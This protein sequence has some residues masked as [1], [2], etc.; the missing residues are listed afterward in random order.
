MLIHV[1]LL[2]KEGNSKVIA[3]ATIP[4]S[5]THAAHEITFTTGEHFT[6]SMDSMQH[7]VGGVII[8]STTWT[9]D[10]G[11]TVEAI[12]RLFLN[13]DA[14]PLD[15]RNAPLVVALRRHYQLR[16][17]AASNALRSKPMISLLSQDEHEELGTKNV[18]AESLLEMGHPLIDRRLQLLH[19]RWR[20]L[21][22][23]LD[24]DEKVD[25]FERRMC[26][27]PIPS[28][29]ESTK[30][31]EKHLRNVAEIEDTEL[32]ETKNVIAAGGADPNDKGKAWLAKLRERKTQ[33]KPVIL[34]DAQK[35]AKI[36][37]V[38]TIPNPLFFIDKIKTWFVPQS[39]FNPKRELREEE[40]E[41]TDRTKIQEKWGA[42]TISCS[43][44]K[45][46]NLPIRDDGSPI[47]AFVELRFVDKAVCTHSMP[48]IAPSWFETLSVPFEPEDFADETLNFIDDDIVLSV[49][50]EVRVP[51][52]R[53][54]TS[55]A[56]SQV[57]HYRVERRFL[58]SVK[59]P[60]YTLYSSKKASIEASFRVFQP[61]VALGYVLSPFDMPTIDLFI[62]LNPPLRKN[63]IPDETD[64]QIRQ[65]LSESPAS[66][67]LKNLNMAALN[68]AV[69]AR[70]VVAQAT[71]F[72]GAAPSAR[73]V[74]PFANT[75]S[76]D[77]QLLCR[78]LRRDGI[79][80]P[81]GITSITEAIRFVSLFQFEVD[82]M[83]SAESDQWSTISE[84][85]N[86]GTGD[87]EEFAILL[88]LLI[89]RIEPG[90]PVYLV[91]GQGDVFP[92]AVYVLIFL[93]NVVD[94]SNP[95]NESSNTPWKLIDPRT[96]DVFD[97][98]S[99]SNRNITGLSDVSLVISHNQIWAN[100][101]PSGNP[102]RMQWNIDDS[103]YWLPMFQPS[104]IQFMQTIE[105][106]QPSDADIPWGLPA[107]K[108]D[109]CRDFEDIVRRQV[110]ETLRMLR[111][112]RNV[113]F[114]E[115]IAVHMR[116][117]LIFMEDERMISANVQHPVVLEAM[118]KALSE[119]GMEYQAV[120]S[121]VNV[122]VRKS[123]HQTLV[124]QLGPLK[125]AIRE[126]AVHEVGAQSAAFAIAVHVR[127]Y[128]CGILSVWVYAVGLVQR[129]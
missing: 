72:G 25:T 96:G 97:T 117:V 123:E 83:T 61:R 115:R 47:Y 55:N 46:A 71:S 42:S 67:T 90:L 65:R 51:L 116:D 106:L 58:G 15:P 28:D 94:P 125:D 41:N 114:H 19:L 124:E 53:T 49:Y 89:R 95:V 35:L 122:S 87:Y 126:T 1:C 79:A 86:M 8:A 93:Q 112:D 111:N 121:P 110:K 40:I 7:K 66:P 127:P 13:G 43:V 113:V 92:Q 103:R 2:Q 31:L 33:G 74:M 29:G 63:E 76:Q 21:H 75:S 14:D 81:P 105:S 4:P 39:G 6:N 68:W 17:A 129:L 69:A 102:N 99:S 100:V 56:T 16:S 50:D 70:S 30:L 18:R 9:T 118:D 27:A 107:A 88:V 64:I 59:V 109:A 85:L 32:T 20:I 104:E 80:P 23:Q 91:T 60:F 119:F 57:T 26:Q 82:M 38:P 101:Q 108:P 54:A 5:L 52:P 10:S 48:G 78:F 62:S 22:N 73:A 44:M 77:L 120:G 84:F 34:T 98:V 128:P 24:P 3:Q 37:T 45:A 12:E 36:I 11:L